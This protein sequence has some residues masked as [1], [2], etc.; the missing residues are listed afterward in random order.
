MGSVTGWQKTTVTV[1]D[2]TKQIQEQSIQTSHQTIQIHALQETLKETSQRERTLQAQLLLHHTSGNT[3]STS[4]SVMA[5]TERVRASKLYNWL[6]SCNTHRIDLSQYAQ[7]IHNADIDL[8]TLHL[9][10]DNDLLVSLIPNLT[11]RTLLKHYLQER[12]H[13]KETTTKETDRIQGLL[14]YTWM[15]GYAKDIDTSLE[16]TVANLDRHGIGLHN[17]DMLL[18]DGISTPLVPN[19]KNRQRI[20]AAILKY[21]EE[22]VVFGT[23]PRPQ[24]SPVQAGDNTMSG[25]ARAR[26]VD[27]GNSRGD[28]GG[29]M[30]PLVPRSPSPF[31]SKEKEETL[32]HVV[33]RIEAMSE[34]MAA[35][36]KK[37]ENQMHTFQSYLEGI[38]TTIFSETG[39]EGASEGVANMLPETTSGYIPTPPP[40]LTERFVAR[41]G[42]MTLRLGALPS[43]DVAHVRKSL[44]KRRRKVRKK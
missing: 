25:V 23:H 8:D 21:R 10:E 41:N 44:N 16:S 29:A 26:V 5:L 14:L 13:T 36:T 2:L 38:Q 31:S 24:W 11:H 12:R 35:A 33:E 17:L 1:A 4:V 3:A 22:G 15:N 20:I 39:R 7:N 6:I 19:Q 43:H 34:S 27:R 37:T 28:D 42:R 18:H 40:V 32:N 9:L 30:G